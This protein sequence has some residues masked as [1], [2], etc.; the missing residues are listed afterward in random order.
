MFHNEKGDIVGDT[1]T[2]N[3]TKG[4]FTL[5]A[6]E[7]RVF[8]STAGFVDFGEQEAYRAGLGKPWTIKVYEG[9]SDNTSSDQFRL[10]FT[11]P[12]DTERR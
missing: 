6:E 2:Q 12:I 1:V 3:F 11:T 5:S 8:S 7:T 10:L 9:P 4:K